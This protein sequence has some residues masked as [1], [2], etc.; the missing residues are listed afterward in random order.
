MILFR[1]DWRKY[2][3][4]IAD[5]KT[6]NRSFVRLAA[7]YREMGI[8]NHMFMLALVNPA[9]QG[10]DP[11][12]YDNLTVEQQVAIGVECSINPWYFFREIARAPAESGADS[13]MVEGNRG[14]IALFWTFFNHILIILIQIR[15]TGKS[16]NVDLL[17]TLLLN[18]ICR[19]TKINLLTKDDDLRRK[20][21]QRLKNIAEELPLYLQQKTRDDANN[22]EEI[23]IK[24]LGN[25]YNT[26]VPQMSEKR[27]L[28]MGRGL[29]SSIFH[30]DEP[31][32]QPNIRIAL[33][34][35]LPAT[36]AAR[37][38]ARSAGAPYGTI[39]TTTAGKIDDK[40]GE[41]VY[42]LMMNAA[43][44]TERF[45]D[46]RNLEE[47]E[48][49]VR[50]NSRGGK[51]HIN[52]TFDHRQL[53]KTDAWL[54]GRLEDA[55]Q[56]GDDANRD[57]FNMW[58]SGSKSNPLP[59]DVLE[60]I[61]K[62]ATEPSY[63]SIA[64]PSGFLTR[65]YIPESTIA[66]RLRTGR[67]VMGM[68]SSNGSGSDDITVCLID[69]EDLSVI[70]AGSYNELNLINF[71]Q[72]LAEMLINMPNITLNPEN[73]SSGTMII[74]YLIIELL[75]VGI[76][77]FRRIFNSVVDDYQENPERYAEINQPMNRRDRHIY[78][79]YK[80]FFGFT[81]AG[82]GK[83]S[84]ND[85]YSIILQRAAAQGKHVMRDKQLTGQVLALIDKN[86]RIDHPA[87]GHDDMVIAW[88]LGN[89]MV[90]MGKN[91]QF[92]GIDSRLVMRLIVK[93]GKEQLDEFQVIEQRQLREK[94]DR[95][96]EDLAHES[97]DTVCLLIEREMRV[98]DRKLIN[99]NGEIQSVDELIRIAAETRRGKK[100]FNR[101]VTSG[102][103][104]G[105]VL[106][107]YGRSDRQAA[108]NNILS[109]GVMSDRPLSLR[110]MYS[111]R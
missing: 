71:A 6:R 30:I 15:Q 57:Y 108:N 58:T 29:T 38:S 73:K 4:A 64:R 78:E 11:Y 55:L 110:E 28:L 68:D 41:Y 72:W 8:K 76:D 100:G 70:A 111:M 77:P 79:K 63:M 81:T 18:F 66:H 32:F 31:P 48:L 106:M 37:D 101:G 1:D 109:H 75:K 80:K 92:Y 97:D 69:V 14:N 91:L 96:Q 17:M 33:K 82:S 93:E 12:D 102:Q 88:L 105:R 51:V 19:D 42:N 104:Y 24:S 16:F 35:A 39:L 7:V 98:L 45:L 50:A 22:G 85:L 95:L 26:H 90:M 46:C 54:R 61:G 56:E 3:T 43:P 84:R 52:A 67:F 62:S 49:M 89:W 47:L 23:S 74:D 25:Y 13:V 10:V 87:G 86:G 44:W 99:D 36:G 34:A 53:G 40:D 9:L 2:P 5:M 20:N 21:I 60:A 103:A 83:F 107:D 27:A 94:L 59:K 65:W